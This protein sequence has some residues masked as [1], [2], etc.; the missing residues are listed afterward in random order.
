MKPTARILVLTFP[1]KILR[2][3][4]QRF[5]VAYLHCIFNRV[6]LC[7]CIYLCL[8]CCLCL[9]ICI[10]ACLYC[11]LLLWVKRSWA[12]NAN[13]SRWHISPLVAYLVAYLQCISPLNISLLYLETSLALPCLVL[14]SFERGKCQRLLCLHFCH[15]RPTCF[16]YISALTYIYTY[17]V[18]F[19]YASSSTLYPCQ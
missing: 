6:N 10:C 7:V 13:V 8:W 4:R 14:S 1:E 12:V 16:W 2:C 17:R 19:S 5:K 3:Q 11:W 9:C 18:F 15:S